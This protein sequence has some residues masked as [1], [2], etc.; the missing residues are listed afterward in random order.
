VLELQASLRERGAHLAA[1]SSRRSATMTLERM[2]L[3]NEFAAVRG[4]NRIT[5]SKPDPE[6]FLPAEPD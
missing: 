1:G 4:G 6:A 3:R 5:R 2:G